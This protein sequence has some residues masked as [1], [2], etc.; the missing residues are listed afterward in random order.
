LLCTFGRI[1]QPSRLAATVIV[2]DRCKRPEPI[3]NYK[4]NHYTLI[5]GD[6]DAIYS[7]YVIESLY[8]KP[9]YDDRGAIVVNLL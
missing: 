6:T 1:I 4:Y 2:H 7:L 5:L 9:L 8:I 3:Y